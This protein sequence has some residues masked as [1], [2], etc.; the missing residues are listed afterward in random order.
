MDVKNLCLLTDVHPFA[1]PETRP[2]L[3]GGP[4]GNGPRSRVLAREPGVSPGAR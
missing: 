1:S 4:S 2:A 3:L